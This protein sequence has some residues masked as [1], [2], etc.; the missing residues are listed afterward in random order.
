MLRSIAALSLAE[1]AHPEEDRG[2]QSS[3]ELAPSDRK[4]RRESKDRRNR[5]APSARPDKRRAVSKAHDTRAP[6]RARNGPCCRR[7]G[8]A[9]RLPCSRIVRHP[10]APD[11]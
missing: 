7:A 9:A 11:T 1:T 3:R 4:A 6:Y 5:E 8:A 10:V 2:A